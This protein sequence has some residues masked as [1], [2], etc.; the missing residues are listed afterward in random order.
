MIARGRPCQPDAEKQCERCGVTF[1]RHGLGLDWKA[2]SVRRFCGAACH[3][4]PVVEVP[5]R[6]LTRA[7]HRAYWTER[8]THQEICE[9]AAYID[10]LSFERSERVRAA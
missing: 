10:F 2:W 1:T 8:F 3:R 7:E 5:F 4:P 9:L 6:R